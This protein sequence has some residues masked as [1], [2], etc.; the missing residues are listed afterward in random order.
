MKHI[1]LTFGVLLS[2]LNLAAGQQLPLWAQYREFN[3]ELN[4]AAADFFTT[5]EVYQNLDLDLA[6]RLNWT[7]IE[8]APQTGLL[9]AQYQNDDLNMSFGGSF[10]HDRFGPTTFSKFRLFYAYRINFSRYKDHALTVGLSAIYSLFRVDGNDLLAQDPNDQLFNQNITNSSAFNAGVGIYYSVEFG[11][12]YSPKYF[13]LGVAMD[14]GLPSNLLIDGN[15][16]QGNL[17]QEMHFNGQVGF[18][19]YYGYERDY[20]EPMVLVRYAQSSPTWYLYGFRATFI[21]QR[22]LV[23]LQ[24]SGSFEP[25]LQ[26][27]FEIIPQ[28]RLGYAL[29]FFLS[30]T[31]STSERPGP[32]HE[33]TLGYRIE[34]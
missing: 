11:D 17:K 14:Q 3:Y 2:I 28:L 24:L 18:R 30:N 5:E 31:F 15:G 27:G 12:G 7:S 9:G 25:Y 29:S 16:G 33:F 23:G 8:G 32:G 34:Y 20:I 22:M 21:D 13:L 10:T 6:Y 19:F 26:A 1:L 4:P